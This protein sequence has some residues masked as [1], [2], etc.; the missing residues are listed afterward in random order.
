MS[1]WGNSLLFLLQSLFILLFPASTVTSHRKGNPPLE[2]IT[3]M[4]AF[5]DMETPELKNQ[6]NKFGVRPLPKRQMVSKLR[7]IHHYTHQ[8]LS[9][10]SESKGLV[11]S[12]DPPKAAAFKEPTG[13]MLKT[14]PKAPPAGQG[15]DGQR[16]GDEEVL[17]AS[18]SSTTSS[19]AASEDSNSDGLTPSQAVSRDAAKLQAVRNFLQSDSEL[20]GQILQYQPLVLAHLQAR[21]KAAGIRLGAAKLL[22]FLDS[23][24]I[25][26]TTA[27]RTKP[28]M[29]LKK[30]KKKKKTEL[31]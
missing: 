9:S 1:S 28:I 11:L 25:T 3:P 10:D 2:P 24:C 19:A 31:E 15:E 5:S 23:Q 30:K 6:L 12:P 26:F 21:L 16:D 8:L 14:C 20:Y 7:E 13:I 22:D 17:S 18:Q 29:K 27:N 4:P